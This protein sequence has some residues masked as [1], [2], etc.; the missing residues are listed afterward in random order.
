MNI[1][2]S[3]CQVQEASTEAMMV[4]VFIIVITENDF[5]CHHHHHHHH[6]HPHHHHHHHHHAYKVNAINTELVCGEAGRRPIKLL[7]PPS[8][9]K[10]SHIIMATMTM[11]TMVVIVTKVTRL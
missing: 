3:G 4:R 1:S 10:V 11:I 5:Y 6:H 8:D 9:Y 7:F 2:I